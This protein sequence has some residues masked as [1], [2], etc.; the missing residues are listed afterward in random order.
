MKKLHLNKLRHLYS[1]I[2]QSFI[3][4]FAFFFLLGNM[5]LICIASML[6]YK[7]TV[8]IIMD[9][10]YKYTY[11]I[12]EQ[13]KS[14]FDTYISSHIAILKSIAEDD[15]L[16][17]LYQCY[18]KGEI[19]N[20]YKYENLITNS[21]KDARDNHPDIMDI[22]VVMDNGIRINRESGWGLNT[23]YDFSQTTWYKNALTYEKDSPVNIFYMNTDFYQNYYSNQYQDVVTISLPVYNYLQEKIGVVFYM[24]YLDQFWTN[25]LNGYHSQ[26]GDLVLTNRENYIIA[27]SKQGS[28]GEYFPETDQA[29]PAD[30]TD[31]VKELTPDKPI[32]LLLSSRE[33]ACNII[34]SLEIDIGRETSQLLKS[35]IIVVILFVFLNAVVILYIS[36]NFNKPIQ[37]LVHDLKSSSAANHNYLNGDY[38]YLELT[39]IAQNFNDLLKKIYRLNKEQTEMQ[40]S[41]QKAKNDI[42][43]SKINPHFLFNSLQLIQ[44]E[45]YYGTKEKTNEIILSLSNQLRYN[46]YDDS[47][48]FVSLSRELERVKE[49]LN[50]CTDIYEGELQTHIDVDPQ[51]L[52]FSVPKFT[53]HVLAENSIKHGFGGTPENGVIKITGTRIQDKMLLSVQDNGAG[54]PP[55][56][57]KT[58]QRALKAGAHTGIGL[59][60]LVKQFDLIFKDQYTVTISSDTETHVTCVIIEIPCITEDKIKN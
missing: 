57:L 3:Y 28:E 54:I 42:L 16:V 19:D 39:F 5:I 25:V 11:A 55:E 23:D 52:P 53:L 15:H 50:L 49:Y 56:K 18:N 27:H 60:N 24:L 2:S 40:I 59:Q 22:L 32:L 44:T 43:I 36:G 30:Q 31:I 26:Y 47:N 7:N 10:S 12:M 33:S 38:R 41:L 14:N 35:I 48:G 58:L 8:G 1:R 37:A 6:F 20:I 34:C 17:S 51:L 9:S 29:V 21:I 13:A 46:I 4:K 45:N